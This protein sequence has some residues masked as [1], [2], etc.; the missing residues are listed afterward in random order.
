MLY[1][2]NRKSY[3]LVEIMIVVAVI[4]ILLAVALPNY[5][6]STTSVERTICINNLKKIDA[7]IDEWAV[8][9]HK[10]PGVQPDA[11][12]EDEISN[13]IRGGKPICPGGGEYAIYAVGNRPQVSC[14]LEDLDHKL[15]E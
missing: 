12:Q 11:S 14:T 9:H 15:L 2:A 13:Y 1:I 5:L 7:A 3:T 8:E 10:S 6:K 4:A